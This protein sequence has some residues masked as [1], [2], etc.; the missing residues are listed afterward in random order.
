MEGAD[1]AV[2]TFRFAGDD[3]E[4]SPDQEMWGRRLLA[5]ILKPRYF[6]EGVLPDVMLRTS[7]PDSLP[8]FGPRIGG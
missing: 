3:P 4:L 5:R 6:E 1:L 2:C 8:S 7:S